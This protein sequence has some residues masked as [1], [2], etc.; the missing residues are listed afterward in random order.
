MSVKEGI[1]L[2]EKKFIQ[3]ISFI[4]VHFV[5]PSSPGY[6]TA[7]IEP[8]RVFS[9]FAGWQAVTRSRPTRGCNGDTP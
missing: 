3:G 9:P 5:H 4:N 7:G 2:P 1:I 8:L 6:G